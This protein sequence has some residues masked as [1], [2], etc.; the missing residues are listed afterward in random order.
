[1]HHRIQY[2]QHAA[3]TRAAAQFILVQVGLQEQQVYSGLAE[4]RGIVKFFSARRV[5]VHACT[6]AAADVEDAVCAFQVAFGVDA[7]AGDDGGFDG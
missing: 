7:A 1:V 2:R 6:F 3:I 4:H 5:H